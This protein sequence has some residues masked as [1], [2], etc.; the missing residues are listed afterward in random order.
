MKDLHHQS[1][2]LQ[3]QTLTEI[4]DL[5]NGFRSSFDNRLTKAE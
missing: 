3:H 5:R 2:D 1:L 4:R